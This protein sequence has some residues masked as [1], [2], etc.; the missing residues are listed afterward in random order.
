[1]LDPQRVCRLLH[2]RRSRTLLHRRLHSILH[3]VAPVPLLP[4]AS[5]QPCPPAT[6]QCPDPHLVSPLLVLRVINRRYRSQ[7]VRLA[8]AVITDIEAMVQSGG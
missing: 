7:R 8:G 2:P 1:M 5:E 3:H 6:R 4:L